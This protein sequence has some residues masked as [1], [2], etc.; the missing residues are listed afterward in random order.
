MCLLLQNLAIACR[1]AI[2][3][4]TIAGAPTSSSRPRLMIPSASAV[5]VATPKAAPTAT[6]APSWTPMPPGTTNAAPRAE[7]ARLS[8]ASAAGHDTGRPSSFSTSQVS[9]T[10]ESQAAMCHPDEA[11]SA[12][13]RRRTLPRARS[14]V[15]L[16][17]LSRAASRPLRCSGSAVSSRPTPTRATTSRRVA[18]ARPTLITSASH[19]RCMRTAA[20]GRA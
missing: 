5:G 20:P 13:G 10:C 1:S 18:V 16:P 11:S 7:E 14:M 3:Q 12:R 17:A 8:I 15:A 9:T 4:A 2:A 6:S 19:P